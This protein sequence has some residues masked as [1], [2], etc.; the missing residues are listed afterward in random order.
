MQRLDI[1]LELGGA[2]PELDVVRVVG[3]ERIGQPYRLEVTVHA[4]A[5]MTPFASDDWVGARASLELAVVDDDD[6]RVR[7]VR[8]IVESVDHALEGRAEAGRAFTLTLRPAL[9]ELERFVTQDIYVG[10]GTPS[11]L[12]KKLELAGVDAFETRI[13]DESAY[14]DHD[15]ADGE[16]NQGRL[17]VQYR[18]TDLAFVSRLAEHAGISYF[19]EEAGGVERAIFTDHDDGF[20]ARA[21]HLPFH[22][23]NAR[24]A[25]PGAVGGGAGLLSLRRS[26]RSIKTQFFAYDYNYRTPHLSFQRDGQILF[27][28]L[29]GEAHLEAPGAGAV[30][31]YAPNVKTPAEAERCARVRAEEE[32]ARRERFM[33]EVSE[34]TLFAGQRVRISGHSDVDEDVE[35]LI[36]ALRH[37]Y[38]SPSF[39][40]SARAPTYRAHLEA[41]RVGKV[42]RAGGRL[43][44][45]PERRTPKPRITGVVTGVV[46]AD[47]RGDASTRQHIDAEGRYLVKLHF[48]QGEKTMPRL[49]MAQPHAGA[50]YGQHFPLR[51]G[52]EVVVAFLDGDPDRPVILGALP[53]P[54]QRSPVTAP[55]EHAPPE[56]NRIRTASGIVFEIGDGVGRSGA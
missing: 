44:F 35:L 48:D 47:T 15:G 3:D 56:V 21:A 33:G 13:A 22:G 19:F 39:H 20:P 53:N 50:G 17:V 52:A 54:V 40:A 16:L 49:R 30:L 7:V 9:A 31:E 38:T 43:H 2:A 32:E 46:Q 4:R 29:G 24:A 37:D 55:L 45:R 51:P 1:R 28:V 8:A 14:V 11:V 10:D 5:D 42:G 41:V 12:R 34:P 18:E 25:R 6:R 26:V 36:V 27:D 23:E